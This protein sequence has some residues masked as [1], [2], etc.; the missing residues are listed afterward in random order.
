MLVWQA[1]SGLTRSNHR[2]G[3][4][5]DRV[6]CGAGVPMRIPRERSRHEPLLVPALA[7][8]VKVDLHRGLELAAREEPS[9]VSRMMGAQLRHRAP[10]NVVGE[11]EYELRSRVG[12]LGKTH[13]IRGMDDG[14]EQLRAGAPRRPDVSLR[15]GAGSRNVESFSVWK[16]HSGHSNQGVG[17]R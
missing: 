13:P 7:H 4:P 5:R 6:E 14:D 3:R 12:D 11:A 8:E 9:N 16:R 10:A 17:M 1:A 15:C 2:L